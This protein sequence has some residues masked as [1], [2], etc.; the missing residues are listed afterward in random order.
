MHIVYPAFSD[1]TSDAHSLT[2]TGTQGEFWRLDVLESDIVRVQHQPDG[3]PRLNRTWLI[4]DEAGQMPR[5]GRSR[6]D[7]S[8]FSRP[9]ASVQALDDGLS[10]RTDDLHIDLNPADS[11]LTWRTADDV[12]F[13]A[14]VRKR[15][16]AY[17]RDSGAV[18][19]YLLRQPHDY[20]YGFGERAGSLNKAGMRFRM[21]NV[22]A[23]GYNAETSD[24]LYKHFPVYITYLPDANVAYG[25]L[26][27]N[28]STTIFDMG[29]EIDAFWGTYRTYQ[30]EAGDLDYY[31]LYGS[32]IADVVEKI[33][34]LTGRPALPPRWSLGYLG[35]TMA[36]TEAADAQE[37]LKNFGRLCREH[38]I[39]C[40]MFHL[41]SGYT[42][43]DD[44]ERRVFTWNR[45]RIPD[46]QQMV[47]DFHAEH[48]RLAPNMKPFLLKTHPDYDDVAARGGF[49]QNA[50][51]N[52]PA[53]SIF[54]RGGAFE[55]GEGAYLDF[56]SE[57]GFGWWQQRIQETLL[58]YGMDALWND[59]NEYELW[60][61]D[62]QCAGFGEPLSVG[63]VRPLH[64]LLMGKASY[65]ALQKAYPDQRPFVISR[66]GCPGIQRYAQTW[67]G[68]NDTSWHTL[69]WNIPMGLGLS[70]SGAPA[71]GHDVGGFHGAAPEPELFLRWIQNGVF[72][73]RF[74]IH[75]WNTDGTVNEPW[76][77]PEILPQVR[78]AIELRYRLLPYLYTLF[79]E[80]YQHG[81]PVIRPLVY[82]F[83]Q[84]TRCYEESFDFLLGAG[85]LVASVLDS[86]ARSRNVYLPQNDRHTE[87]WCD[88]H[89]G[90]WHAGGQSVTL[91][92]PLERLPLLVRAGQVIPMGQVMRYVGER[93]DDLRELHLFPHPQAGEGAFTLLEDDGL[94]N[95]YQ[96]GEVTRLHLTLRATPEA[97]RLAVDVLQDGYPLP[98]DE[99]IC[100]LPAGDARP[101]SVN[102]V[103]V[104][105]QSDDGGQRRGVIHLADIL[106]G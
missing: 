62:A 70:L 17:D 100:V 94:S 104:P 11:T 84:D 88:W 102:G 74:T 96:R 28:L 75:S 99:F 27:D 35:S 10:I 55:W 105:L 23:L 103:D 42:T 87:Q 95:G 73:P 71:T 26:Y 90:R 20:Y 77:Y 24:P 59:N 13:A 49:I 22:D 61:D 82:A 18:Y 101:L 39:P 6:D 86:G 60:Q 78:R 51:G 80:A 83:P 67:S 41:S 64:T 63:Q 54:W 46:P 48:I 50:A 106:A 9:A 4:V 45:D 8:P 14:D 44:G 3:S 47:N 68:D 53:D 72:H 97:V 36:Y 65:E 29:K 89:S 33:T 38:A 79:Y 21:K 81:T 1:V 25:L 37:Q 91:D 40:D 98:Y 2:M 85:L 52:A 57:A 16:Y 19:H 7:L 56:T 58:D 76:M 34:R 30:A 32:T 93:P 5:E 92:A 66:S 43:A 15:A 31:L 69:R 12:L